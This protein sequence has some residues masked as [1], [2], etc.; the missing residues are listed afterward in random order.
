M[1][2]PSKK[3]IYITSAFAA[4]AGIVGVSSY[5]NDIAYAVC[6]KIYPEA[7]DGEVR[8]KDN[9]GN[10]Y[11]LLNHG[12]GK[13]TALFDDD[14]SVTFHRE[15]DGSLV[16]DA[17]LASLLPSIAA[18]YYIFHGFNPPTARMDGRTMTYRIA[19]PLQT[20]E[21]PYV[22]TASGSNVHST[23]GRS[24]YRSYERNRSKKASSIGQKSG[25]GSAGARSSAS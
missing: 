8:L 20:Y 10:R 9:Q 24:L 11:S 23:M 7:N 5:W 1:Y 25:F 4:V 13:E 16:W 6:D 2:K 3:T 12:D 14:R 15:K 18:G 22:Y 17:G 19:A 21:E